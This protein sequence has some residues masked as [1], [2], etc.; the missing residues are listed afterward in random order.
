MRKSGEMMKTLL[1]AA[2]FLIA[3]LVAAR[4]ALAGAHRLRR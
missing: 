3:S 2:S 1:L 4:P